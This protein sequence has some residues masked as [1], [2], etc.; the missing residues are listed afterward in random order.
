MQR[1][2]HSLVVVLTASLV[3]SISTVF[4]QSGSAKPSFFNPDATPQEDLQT[5][6]NYF[7]QRFPELPP[8]ELANGVYALDESMRANW[9]QIEEF[10]PY[11]PAIEQGRELWETAFANGQTYADCFGGP[12]V[13]NEYPRWDSDRGEVITVPLAIN[14]CRTQNG[15]EPYEYRDAQM[16]AVHA[17][18]AHESRGKPTNVQIPT[19]D[20]RAMAA[21]ED[22]KTFYFSRRGQLSLACYHCHFATS[23]QRLRANILGPARGQTTHWPAYRSKWGELGSLQRRYSGCNQQ[24]R[25]APQEEQSEAYRNLELFHTHM[26]NGVPLNG[27]GA[28]Q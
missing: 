1:L 7:E 6:R 10:P 27:P 24:V 22:G 5:F 17:Y 26:S 28:R 25:A 2:M 3:C 13:V 18:M 9:E 4:A 19:D 16:L 8:E 23:G 15:E 14:E 11:E 21:Y 20:P 12:D